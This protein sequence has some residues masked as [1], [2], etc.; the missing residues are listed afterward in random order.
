MG[1]GAL[2]YIGVKGGLDI[3]G[4]IQGYYVYAGENISAGDFV[5]FVN[6]VAGKV[7]AGQIIET[8]YETQV[9]RATSVPCNGVA[10]TSGI[11]GDETAHNEQ[12]KVVQNFILKKEDI[13]LLFHLVS[14]ADMM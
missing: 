9:R 2:D 7:N 10:K 14:L 1:Q 13:I 6:G 5:E 11:G 8:S 4:I 3:N 12:V